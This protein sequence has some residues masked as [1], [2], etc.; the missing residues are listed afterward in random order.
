MT[1]AVPARGMRS[2]RERTCEGRPK[3]DALEDLFI[4]QSG[5][6]DRNSTNLIARTLSVLHFGGRESYPVGCGVGAAVGVIVAGGSVLPVSSR[7]GG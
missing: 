7:K 3:R 1:L 4:H 6:D 2:T 5:F